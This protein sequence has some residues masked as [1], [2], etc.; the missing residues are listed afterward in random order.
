LPEYTK[1]KY[2]LPER[3]ILS[4]STIEPRKNLERGL[5]A[6]SH[7]LSQKGLGTIKWV[8]AGREGWG[9]KTFREKMHE[10]GL[11]ES[12][13]LLGHVSDSDLSNLY[14]LADLLFFPSLYE[15]FG[16]P[17]IEAM[18]NGCP[19]VASNQHAISEVTGDAAIMVDPLNPK[20]MAEKMI[21]LMTDHSLRSTIID[22][23]LERSRLFTWQNTANQTLAVLRNIVRPQLGN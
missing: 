6:F 12:V 16:L 4:V 2:G 23:G 21:T 3:F 13:I 5:L 17:P 19:V 1:Q 18:A 15:G 8:I 20:D 11:G 7:I 14:K 10:L 22:S 9:Y